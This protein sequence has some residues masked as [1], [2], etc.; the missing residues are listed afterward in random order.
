MW[1]PIDVFFPIYRWLLLISCSFRQ[2]VVC[3]RYKIEWEVEILDNAI[4]LLAVKIFSSGRQLGWRW[5]TLTLS[6]LV[7]FQG[8]AWLF[9]GT[10][11]S[12][13]LL[14]EEGKAVWVEPGSFQRL[15]GLWWAMS[16]LPDPLFWTKDCSYTV[17]SV[18]LYLTSLAVIRVEGP[19]WLS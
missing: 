2:N 10:I 14:S 7:M 19:C 1:T 12:L 4:F 6:D 17:A 5:K 18:Q 15:T 9:A 11:M 8:S 13:L 16:S 3:S